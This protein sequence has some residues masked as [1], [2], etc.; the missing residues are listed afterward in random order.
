[1]KI[2][3]LA[4]HAHI[5]KAFSQEKMISKRNQ[6]PPQAEN[7]STNLDRDIDR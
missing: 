4:K 3:I 1:M 5:G 2:Y 7:I 6:G